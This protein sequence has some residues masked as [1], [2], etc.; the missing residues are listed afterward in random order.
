MSEDADKELNRQAAMREILLDRL[1]RVQRQLESFHKLH[2]D[3]MT[4]LS[5]ELDTKGEAA[6]AEKLRTLVQLHGDELEMAREEL[7]D[8]SAELQIYLRDL[9]LPAPVASEPD[10]GLS[11]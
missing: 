8:T 1:N 4:S 10:P 3:D 5:S 2:A 7:T 6:L 9:A 11:A